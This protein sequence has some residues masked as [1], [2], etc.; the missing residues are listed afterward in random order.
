MSWDCRFGADHLGR[1]DH[2]PLSFLGRS[3]I[4]GFQESFS[5]WRR[6]LAVVFWCSRRCCQPLGL[7]A[8]VGHGRGESLPF[9]RPVLFITIIPY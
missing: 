7:D 9:V 6:A 4:P 5:Q 8:G 1:H 3:D 2:L